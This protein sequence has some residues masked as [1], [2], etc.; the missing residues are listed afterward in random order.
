MPR[1]DDTVAV[2]T[3]FWNSL[4]IERPS[5]ARQQKG[6]EIASTG[7]GLVK[8]HGVDAKGSVY[9]K[10]IGRRAIRKTQMV[11]MTPTREVIATFPPIAE[12]SARRTQDFI[13][14]SQVPQ[15]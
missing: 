8:H 10:V 13:F 6:Q 5:P 9:P 14:D 15:V 7:R 1:V 12:K 4:H 2:E 11:G 3:I